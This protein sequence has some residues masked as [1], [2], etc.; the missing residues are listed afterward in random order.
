M[1]S[2]MT[3]AT[4]EQIDTRYPGRRALTPEAV[5]E[6]ERQVRVMI[7]AQRFVLQSGEAS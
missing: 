6:I 2:T 4:R 5:A 3:V 1:M 7:T